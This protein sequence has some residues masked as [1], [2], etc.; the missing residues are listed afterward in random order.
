MGEVTSHKFEVAAQDGAFNA[1]GFA[2]QPTLQFI[3][4]VTE[5]RPNLR[6]LEV[7]CGK[8]H[9]AKALVDKG[10]QVLPIDVS[11]GAV[12]F[13][14]SLGLPARQ[15][16][17]FGVN[18]SA[19]DG[20]LFIQSLHHIN[21]LDQ[22]LAQATRLLDKGGF[23]LVDDF[24]FDKI[25]ENTA[26]WFQGVQNLLVAAGINAFH[27][28][29]LDKAFVHLMNHY[30]EHGIHTGEELIRALRNTFR[31]VDVS[32]GGTYLY[33]YFVSK[34]ESRSDG[35]D[36]IKAIFEWEEFQI[37][38]RFIQGVGLRLVGFK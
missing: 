4:S 13:A 15:T 33:R 34:T 32:D 2:T 18:D 9:L 20:I 28:I 36:L 26:V 37:E 17:I 7:G 22:S 24:A 5:H 23:V 6:F 8:G 35:S 21:P 19:F 25:D 14:R 31:N 16:D 11:E 10:H 1:S 12:A 27:R 29:D 3:E 38:K 30:S